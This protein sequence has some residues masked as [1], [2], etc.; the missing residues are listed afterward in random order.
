MDT[1]HAERIFLIG[2][3]GSG[4][5]TVGRAV[6]ALLGWQFVDT[7]DLIAT[8]AG[9]RIPAIFA[10]NGEPH[11][12]DLESAAL[13]DAATRPR[14]VI[15]TGAGIVERPANI[16][17]MRGAGW[18]VE[19]VCASETALGRLRAD[20]VVH[21]T[22]IGA[23]RPMLAVDAI[24]PRL[25]EIA[26]RRRAAYRLHD[27]GVRTDELAPDEVARSVLAGL[28]GRGLMPSDGAQTF[29]HTITAGSSNY[30][31]VMAWGGV[32]TLGD[33]LRALS[34]RQR[35]YLVADANVYALYE[36]QLHEMFT[37]AGIGKIAYIAPPGEQSKSAQQLSA[38]YDWLAEHHAERR[39]PLVAIGGGVVGDLAG[40]AAATYLRGMPLVH[41]PT[42]LL[43][44]VDSSLGGKTGIN[45]PRGKNLIGAFYPPRLVLA[46]PALLLSLPTR[47]RIE[48]WAEVVKH[49]VALDAE[50]FLRLERDV[51]ALLA[52]RPAPLT[53]AIAG[54][55]AIKAS[56]VEGDEHEVEGGR[57]HLLN[58][59]HTIGHAIEAVAGYGAWLH[60]EAVAVGM[61][62]AAR[63]GQRLG[64][65]PTE[66]VNRQE[67]LLTRFGLPTRAD[68]LASDELL[69]AA[70]WDKKVS[71]GTVRW[72]LP[73][74]LGDSTLVSDVPEDDVRAALR[75]I[76]AAG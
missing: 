68:G 34:S 38:I 49:G 18:V 41:V 1:Q 72:V 22:A 35:I 54:S 4:K 33:R 27:D 64:I 76:G 50:Y 45:H 75:E 40:Y 70:L 44:Q 9:K 37:A 66:V 57:R 21:N 58:Y 61:C 52:M 55:V 11:F 71:R 20:A 30:D 15:A 25:E 48:G 3:T 24:L 46:D 39:D 53:E 69:H 67:A 73:T 23:L 51:D 32:A 60:G 14:A 2:P 29:T 8:I 36:R 13:A 6:A 5:T 7:D 47:Q 26:T 10:E 31:A 62:A 59:G 12:R 65:T 42:T 19:L 43:A 28:V 63:L 16:E 17:L 74:C 56:V